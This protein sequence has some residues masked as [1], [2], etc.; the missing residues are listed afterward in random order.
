MEPT[1]SPGSYICTYKKVNYNIGDVVV[2]SIADDLK[3]IKRIFSIN[4]QKIKLC[5]DNISKSSTLCEPWYRSQDIIGKV[6]INFSFINKFLK[7]K[8]PS[9]IG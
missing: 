1:I 8:E 6:I 9:H 5:G 4:N 2:V 3:I 7:P